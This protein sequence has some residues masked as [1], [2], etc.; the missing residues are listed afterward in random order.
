MIELTTE[1]LQVLAHPQESPPRVLNPDTQQTFVLLPLADYQRLIEDEE[2]D[3]GP[4]TDEERDLLRLEAC[5]M[6][7]SFGKDA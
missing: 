2:Y 7:D 5:Q 1:Q 3:D 6:L 4:W